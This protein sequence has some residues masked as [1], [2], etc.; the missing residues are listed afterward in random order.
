M[1]DY[2]GCCFLYRVDRALFVVFYENLMLFEPLLPRCIMRLGQFK[3]LCVVLEMRL[4]FPG[5]NLPLFGVTGTKAG[6]LVD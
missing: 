1:G 5:F 2:W 3:I 6:F 4:P